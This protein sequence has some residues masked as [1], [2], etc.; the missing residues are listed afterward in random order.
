MSPVDRADDR[1]QRW[2]YTLGT[3]FNVIADQAP[4]LAVAAIFIV[5]TKVMGQHLDAAAGFVTFTV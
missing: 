1:W 2:R 4:V 3:I 5:H